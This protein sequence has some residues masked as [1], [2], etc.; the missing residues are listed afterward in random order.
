MISRMPERIYIGT[1]TTP[2]RGQGPGL[3]VVDANENPW[4]IQQV[5]PLDNPGSLWIDSARGIMHAAH[6]DGEVVTSFRIDSDQD[7]TLLG[8]RETQGKNPTHLAL[9]PEGDHLVVAN[10]SSGSVVSLPIDDDGVPG[11]ATDQ[12]VPFGERGP[13]R[14]EQAGPKPHQ[15]FF[16]RDGK[17]LVVPDKGL[18][19]VFI[20]TWEGQSGLIRALHTVELRQ[21]SG[22][23]HV[24][25]HPGRSVLYVLNELDSTIAVIHMGAFLFREP[26]V[27]QVL[28]TLP[29][30][31]PRD[32]RASELV[33]S[34]DGRFLYASNRSGAGDRTPG[35]P[36]DDSIA[37]FA[38][39]NDG[40]LDQHGH[41]SSCGIRPRFICMSPMGESLWVANEKSG[42]IW[43]LPINGEDGSLGEGTSKLHVDSPVWIAWSQSS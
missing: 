26:K 35:G 30:D 16:T 18:D 39:R 2:D 38:V 41:S 24:V 13:H 43:A 15:V 28:T 21:G 12:F 19:R 20:C 34:P 11:P 8:T 29:P 37:V 5:I 10:H 23:R 27:V 9:S 31:D 22:P 32:S 6:G 4:R 3:L 42:G 1:R 40:R 33:L 17:H 36:R 14:V 7:L 25:E